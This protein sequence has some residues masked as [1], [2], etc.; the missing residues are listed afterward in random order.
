L[1][2]VFLHP[3]SFNCVPLALAC[4]SGPVVDCCVAVFLSLSISIF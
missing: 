3:P 4:A 2:V 1:I